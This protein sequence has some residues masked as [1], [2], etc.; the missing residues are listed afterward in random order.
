V[1]VWVAN[2]IQARC[3][4]RSN[5]L[6]GYIAATL[7]LVQIFAD[8]H[9]FEEDRFF[10]AQLAHLQHRRLAGRRQGQKPVELGRQIDVDPVERHAL[11]EEDDRGAG[12]GGG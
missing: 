8:D 10:T 11:F 3:R 5:A 6:S 9:A 7:R 2:S 4:A 12:T 1:K